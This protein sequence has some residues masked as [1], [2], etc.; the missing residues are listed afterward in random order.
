MWD[1]IRKI[2]N[3]LNSRFQ[4]QHVAFESQHLSLIF[5]ERAGI[6]LS[7]VSEHRAWKKSGSTG[8]PHQQ[9]EG[10]ECPRE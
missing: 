9:K 2:P 5:L 3:C 4:V 7:G 6:A 10:G 1:L 8:H